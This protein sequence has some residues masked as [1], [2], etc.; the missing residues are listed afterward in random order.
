MTARALKL[1][2][3][4]RLRV[5]K[6]Q[7]EELGQQA[8]VQFE[9]NFFR[10][11]E[12]LAPVRGFVISWLL[13]MV[14][15]VGGV[16]L[17]I[18]AL[19]GW[20]QIPEPTPGGTYTEGIL[21]SFTN[22]N[23][24]YATSPVDSAVSQLIFAGLF[25]YN[26]KNQLVGDLATGWSVDSAGTTYTVHLR[27]QLAWQ[28]GQPLTASDVA[29]TYHV[30][31]NADAQSPL[32]PS[33]QGITV[34]AVNPTTVT[35]ELANP[36]SSFPYSMT[37]GIIPEH[38]LGRVPMVDMR[39]VAFN[40]ADP[41]GAG[42]FAWQAIQVTGDSA[43]NQEEQIALKPSTGYYGGVPKLGSFVVRT[44]RS[45]DEMIHSFQ[46]QQITAMVGLK[47]VPGSL[48]H[49]KNLHAYNMPL[50]AAVMTFFKTSSGALANTD[51]REALV[52]AV[53]TSAVI[54]NLGY[55]ALPVVE[56][57]LSGQMAYDPG[58]A[59]AGYSPANAAAH[60]DAAGW[61]LNAQGIRTQDGQPLTFHLLA[62]DTS[63]YAGVAR[64]LQRYWHQV[65]V[66]AQVT[67]Q[68]QTDFQTTLADHS[69]DALL[70]GI[71]IGVDPDTFVYWDSSQAALNSPNHLN[72]SEYKS[73]AADESLEG[74][75]TR[76][77]AAL[78]IIKYRSF[79]QAWQKDSPALGLYQ[80][81]FLYITHEMVFGL[82]S[83][84]INAD[85]DRFKNV[86]NWEI[87]EKGVS[88]DASSSKL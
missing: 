50:T 63:E 42:P 17:Q 74:G 8:G 66:Q 75:R 29:F 65:G 60:L 35:F 56:P 37:N 24:L 49:D 86:Q 80:P 83:Q 51:V 26:Q 20:F 13:L 57:L 59:Q 61:H 45:Q 70:Y 71:S 44:F 39:S 14:L 6:R 48:A 41:V 84:T 7:V 23:P 38:L 33:W 40:T 19:N 2:F 58:F 32:N 64:Q 11:L 47:S 72:F 87:R 10:R 46:Q 5:R 25:K 36:L 21:G 68:D 4:R 3:R 67:L 18:R 62:P 27:P 22:A 28:D 69:Y 55:A 53:D 73:A 34:K 88:Q 16:G 43:D 77:D 31:Q 52:Q 9:Q 76:Q 78:R 82:E 15:L 85:V 12:R 30:I 54:A 1:R 81:R 79:L